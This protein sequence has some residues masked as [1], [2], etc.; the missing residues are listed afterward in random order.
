MNK[1]I[2]V[3]AAMDSVG[4]R[5]KARTG[6]EDRYWLWP[7]GKEDGDWTGTR[8]HSKCEMR[9]KPVT[10]RIKGKEEN[11]DY[12]TSQVKRAKWIE[13][14]MRAGEVERAVNSRQTV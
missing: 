3:T 4:F 14:A 2:R 9:Q 8:W 6:S 11:K 1:I 5:G 7:V 13:E 12:N 10:I